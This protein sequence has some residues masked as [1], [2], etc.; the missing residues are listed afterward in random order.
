MS[1]I[2][3]S[4]MVLSGRTRGRST[5]NGGLCGN[6]S[7][8]ADLLSK[9]LSCTVNSQCKRQCLEGSGRVVSPGGGMGGDGQTMATLSIGRRL[10]S[11]LDHAIRFDV[12]N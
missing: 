11:I 4:F 7:S 6:R 5:N 9:T 12:I 3:L 2:E 8:V 10:E 1:L